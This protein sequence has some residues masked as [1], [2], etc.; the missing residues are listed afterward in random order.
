MTAGCA[1]G[2]TCNGQETIRVRNTIFQGQKVY[3]NPEEDTCFA[4][5]DDESSPP[6]PADPFDVERSLVTG[7]RFGN[8]TPCP[9]GDNLCDVPSGLADTSIDRFDPVPRA[10]SPV[11]DAGLVEGAPADDITGQPRD[12]RP[13]IGACERR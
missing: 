3:F 13:D 9:G 12:G 10:G 7:V 6:M 2:K 8:V 1:V 11:V 5:Y 4:W